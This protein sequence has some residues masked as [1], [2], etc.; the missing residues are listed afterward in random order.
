VAGLVHTEGVWQSEQLF[1]CD[2]DFSFLYMFHLGTLRT[3]LPVVRTR[4]E[5]AGAFF[6]FANTVLTGCR[7]RPAYPTGR[8]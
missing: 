4:H 7:L 1:N 6:K 3:A 8:P 2:I 5:M